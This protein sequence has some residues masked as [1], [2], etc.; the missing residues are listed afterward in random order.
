MYFSEQMSD[1]IT[2]LD[3]PR[4]T[5]VNKE[6][7]RPDPRNDV[8]TFTFDRSDIT[9]KEFMAFLNKK[10]YLSDNINHEPVNFIIKRSRDDKHKWILSEEFDR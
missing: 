4:L 1:L 9:L 2:P 3:V 7:T 10:G 5:L 8:T 6:F